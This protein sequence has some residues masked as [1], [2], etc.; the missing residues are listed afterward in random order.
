M[1]SACS[2]V[3][4]ISEDTQAIIE[5]KAA[6]GPRKALL[7]TAILKAKHGL[8]RK[9]TA[10]AA[11]IEKTSEDM[12][13]L[14]QAGCIGYCKAMERF[15]PGRG[16]AISTFAAWWVRHEVQRVARGATVVALPRIRLKNE[17]RARAVLAL[18]ADPDVAPESIGIRRSQLEQVRNSIGVKFL[19]DGVER[20]ARAVERKFLDGAGPFDAEGALDEARRYRALDQ[21][22][23][24]VRNGETAEQI[25]IPHEGYVAALEIIRDT[26]EEGASMEETTAAAKKKP[27]PKPGTPRKPAAP[28]PKKPAGARERFAAHLAELDAERKLI[29]MLMSAPEAVVARV[30][31]RFAA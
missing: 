5:W 18:R 1:G 30:V 2:P 21:V 29:E 6:R 10:K 28:K 31:A 14:F 7:L 20:G 26:N 8:I 11:R 13:D 27:G 12:D 16:L 24:R 22:V 3:R 17:E 4:S 19:S 9:L 23:A 15:D 25:G